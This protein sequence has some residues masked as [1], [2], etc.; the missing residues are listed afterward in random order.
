MAHEPIQFSQHARRDLPDLP[1]LEPGDEAAQPV[2]LDL[3]KETAL[4]VKWNDGRVSTY[5]VAYL[6]K[7]SP[8]AE[9]RQLREEI[10]RNPLTVLP[11][12]AGSAG[13]AKPFAAT[14]AEFVGRYALRIEFSDGHRTGIYTWPYLRQIDPG[15][16][17]ASR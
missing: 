4:T 8:S 15:R 14:G 12:N 5:P 16:P 11:G 6:R 1:P 3:Q 13:E 2:S 10:A 17:D 9:A 7:M